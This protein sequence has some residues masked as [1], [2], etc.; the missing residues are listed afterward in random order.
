[1]PFASVAPAPAL[2]P[3]PV[4][5]PSLTVQAPAVPA[6]GSGRSFPAPAALLVLGSCT[7]LQVGAALATR[8]FPVAGAT[9]TTLL[10]LGLAACAL[11]V[12]TRP[13]VRGWTRGQWGAVACFGFSLGTMN[14]F[15]YASIS[16]IPLG[17]AVTIEFLGPLT[18]AAVL[19]RRARDLGW[20]LLALVGVLVLGWAGHDGGG[21]GG[22]LDMTGVL[23]A[24]IAG[25]CWALYI[26]TG[27]RAG[28]AVPGRG[29]LAVAMSVG[30]LMLLPLGASG[31]VHAI[32]RPSSVLTAAG[33]AVAASIVP[34]TLE[35]A[36]LRRIPRNVFGILLSLE[37][38]VAALA[39]WLLLSQGLGVP[40]LVG[41]VATV[42][43]GAGSALSG[44]R[45][46]ER[47]G[48]AEAGAG[49]GLGG[50]PAIGETVS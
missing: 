6:A 13:R 5:V 4:A 24:L 25:G 9:G 33:T 28:A 3:A 48:G 50:R 11:L 45:S 30:A 12:T 17:V 34:Y 36:A 41:I 21:A 42:V 19:S 29:G 47:A 22:T 1:M 46:R 20:V 8:L 15:F 26:V 35:L 39:G 18:L 2:A 23:F 32:D 44:P 37:P 7:S 27:A 38:A 40:A 10:R 49:S 14:G 43:A 16:R 31:A